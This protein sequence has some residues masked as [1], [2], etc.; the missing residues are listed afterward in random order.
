MGDVF[1]VGAVRSPIGKL[2]GAFSGLSAPELAAPVMAMALDRARVDPAGLDLIAF[3]NVLRGGL[4]QLVPRQ[5]ALL[6]GIP[7]TVDAVA[8][9][10]VCSSGMMSVIIASALI[11]AGDADILLAGGVESMSGAGFVV[12]SEARNK[13]AY[14]AE[15]AGAPQDMLMVDG[16]TNPRTGASMGEEAERLREEA[17]I[18]R[19]ELDSIAA[20]SHLRASRRRRFDAEIVPVGPSLGT[21]EGVRANTSVE[22]LSALNP[23]F[24][25]DGA[26]TAGNSSQISDGAAALVLA[27]GDAVKTHGLLP[28]AR[29][30]GGS[31]VAGTPWRFIEAPEGAVQRLLKRV[32]LTLPDVDLFENN[33][34][35]ALSSVLFHRALG[36][37]YD[38]LNVHGGAIALG[39]PI[40]CSG[41]R[42]LVTLLHA[43]EAYDKNVGMASICHG[44]GGATAVL[45]ERCD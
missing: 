30:L 29:I 43:L 45:M 21:D 11:R 31:W 19:E 27:S 6:A 40:G 9:D 37:G 2:G 42:I 44:L 1:I 3:G 36:V 7:R 17:G 13:L 32:A 20:E 33:E 39:H 14:V 38:R 16:L 41:A 12:S 35:F 4:G 10:M 28:R 18:S 23:V 5:A 26:L 8:M 34:A 25:K 24:S 22:K 15:Q